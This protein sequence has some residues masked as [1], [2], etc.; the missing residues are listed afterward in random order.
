MSSVPFPC[1]TKKKIQ[2][3]NW[4]HKARETR[5]LEVFRMRRLKAKP[6]RL[7]TFYHL[8]WRLAFSLLVES[9]F[10]SS[11][12][13][14]TSHKPYT[15]KRPY[16]KV[17]ENIIAVLF[18]HFFSDW[19]AIFGFLTSLSNGICMVFPKQYIKA[20]Y[21]ISVPTIITIRI[22]RYRADEFSAGW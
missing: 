9:V 5:G 18:S 13:G 7:S 6:L 17:L 21:S 14:Q 10:H 20:S 11:V 16:V 15:R 22:P 4:R 2:L 3:I 19:I 8:V 12:G 1:N